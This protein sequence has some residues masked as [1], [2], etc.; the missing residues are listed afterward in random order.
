MVSPSVF[1]VARLMQS[2]KRVGSS[3][4]MPHIIGGAARDQALVRAVGDQ[5]AGIQHFLHIAAARQFARQRKL[6]DPP[7]ADVEHR[8]TPSSIFGQRK[9]PSWSRLQRDTGHRPLPSQNT[10]LIRSARLARNT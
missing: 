3:T 6:R 5:R 7:L 4:G 9:I 10:S 1:A 2:S 8:I